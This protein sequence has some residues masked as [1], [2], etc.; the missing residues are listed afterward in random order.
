MPTSLENILLIFRDFEI[1]LASVNVRQR[2]RKEF[3]CSILQK[4]QN[5]LLT[6]IFLI[7][8][9]RYGTYV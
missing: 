9:L 7:I 3:C 6:L 1:A 5:A 2:I 8:K 4:G